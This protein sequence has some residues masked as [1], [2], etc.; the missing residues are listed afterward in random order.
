MY[1]G[2]VIAV[3]GAIPPAFSRGL[4]L[5]VWVA[6]MRALLSE[7]DLRR[8]PNAALGFISLESGKSEPKNGASFTEKIGGTVGTVPPMQGRVA[9]PARLEAPGGNLFPLFG[10]FDL[11]GCV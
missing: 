11:I 10:G 7:T 3:V 2:H 6:V 8:K 1:S 9:W 4:R 5:A